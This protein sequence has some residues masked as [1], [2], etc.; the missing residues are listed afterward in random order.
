V[1]ALGRIA[2][3]AAVAVITADWLHRVIVS[4]TVILALRGQLFP[5]PD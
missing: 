2:P 3:D 1:T 5:R 4:R